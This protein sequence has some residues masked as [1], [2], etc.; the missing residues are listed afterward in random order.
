MLTKQFYSYRKRYEGPCFKNHKAPSN[1]MAGT[2][3]KKKV[4][5]SINKYFSGNK[6]AFINSVIY[7]QIQKEN[8]TNLSSL[9]QL[10]AT[11]FLCDMAYNSFPLPQP[12]GT[13]VSSYLQHNQKN[14]SDYKKSKTNK[15]RE[16]SQRICHS[17]FRITKQFLTHVPDRGG[18]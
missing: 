1:L 2:L 6:Q 3:G 7:N 16:M 15:R 8:I 17:T 12:K 10:C 18:V 4:Q 9:F 5:H 14:L 11:L 13:K